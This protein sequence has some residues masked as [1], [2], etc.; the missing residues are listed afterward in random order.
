MKCVNC[1]GMGSPGGCARCGK[2]SLTEVRS[3]ELRA[4]MR[5]QFVPMWEEH[6]DE[7][8]GVPLEVLRDR[9][10]REDRFGRTMNAWWCKRLD[11]GMEGYIIFGPQLE[12]LPLEVIA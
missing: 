7:R 11:T 6:E 12:I 9:E 8:N 2:K 4:G 5:V 3:D 10:D 1:A